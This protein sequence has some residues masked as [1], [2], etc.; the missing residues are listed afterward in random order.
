[1]LEVLTNLQRFLENRPVTPPPVG[2][3]LD[4]GVRDDGHV[5]N[6]RK[7]SIELVIVPVPDSADAQLFVELSSYGADLMEARYAL[8]LA[9]RGVEGSPLQDAARYLSGFAALAY[10][11]TYFPSKVRKPL[12]DHVVIPEDLRDVHLLIDAFRNTTI[13][14]SQSELATTFPVAVIDASSLQLRD[15][16]ASTVVQPLLPRQVL[17][18]LELVKTVDELLFE[19][20][21]PVRQRLMTEMRRADLV[22]MVAEGRLPDFVDATDADFKPR[23][24]RQPYPAANTVYWSKA[25]ISGD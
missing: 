10:C 25:A 4:G 21:E 15:V 1:M 18:F 16:M 3:F 6:N 9:L 22:G 14:H 2:S 23:T 19:V 24:T 11:R 7:T 13:A 20:T 8:E 17:R 5:S 12:T